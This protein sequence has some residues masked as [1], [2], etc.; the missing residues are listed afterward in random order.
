MTSAPVIDT[1]PEDAIARHS[2]RPLPLPG[3]FVGPYRLIFELASGGMAKIYL[4]IPELRVAAQRLVAGKR[5]HAHLADDPNFRKM[6]L[7]EARIAS[8]LRHPNVCTVFDYDDRHGA[9]YIVMEYLAG[10][11]VSAVWKA[12]PPGISPTE[13]RRRCVLAARIV[14]DACEALH[15]AHELRSIYGEPLNVVHRDVSPE[16]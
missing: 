16:N 4:A 6:F 13:M 3:E 5:L 14:A 10:E 8:H 1:L 12:L 7:D 9:P 11:P 15:A 2:P